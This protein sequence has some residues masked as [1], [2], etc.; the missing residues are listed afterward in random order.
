MKEEPAPISAVAPMTP[1]ALDRVVRR[2]LAKDPE[3]RWQNAADLR[4][5][6][7]WI[8]E[9][10]SPGVAAPVAVRGRRRPWLPWAAALVLA[11]AG[12][13]AG[14]WLPSAPEA[15]QGLSRCRSIC[16]TRSWISIGNNA[17]LALSPDGTMLALMATGA[18]RQ[19]GSSGCAVSTDSASSRSPGPTTRCPFWSPDSKFIGFFAEQKLKKVPAAGGTVQTICDAADGRGA[20]WS[21]HDVIVFAPAPFGGLSRVP[22]AGGTPTPLTREDR[23][24]STHRL[25][26]FLPDGKRLL[27]FAGSQ[28]SDLEK[29]SA[30]ECLDLASG[31][32]TTVAKEPSE[33]RYAEPGYLLCS[34][35]KG[36]LMAQPFD[37]S[38][39]DPGTPF[40]SPSA[41]ASRRRAGPGTSP[42]RRRV[43]SC[44]RPVDRRAGTS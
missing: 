15:P 23:P 6:L 3:D 34:C 4:S 36:N 9:G 26:W 22:A 29:T 41:F 21:I 35:A 31:K 33:G 27:F 1:P 8:A 17:S 39:Q 11:V 16:R 30:I 14:G 2:C 7:K 5:E 24:G 18:R 20:S 28:S 38:P 40:R 43:C 44:F 13:A 10:G 19:S 32:T 42:C 37:P 25:P 12:F